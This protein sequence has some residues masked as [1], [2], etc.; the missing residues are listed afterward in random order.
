MYIGT[1]CLS[2]VCAFVLTLLFESPFMALD[3][4]IFSEKVSEKTKRSKA[5]DSEKSEES[6]T[7]G[8]IVNDTNSDKKVA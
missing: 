6:L 4:L 3:K 2:F 1:V 8:D 5:L 7:N